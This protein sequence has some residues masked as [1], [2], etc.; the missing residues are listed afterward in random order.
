MKYQQVTLIERYLISHFNVKGY[1]ISN[2]AKELSRHKST[3]YRELKRNRATDGSYKSQRAFE[4]ATARRRRSRRNSHFTKSDWNIVDKHLKIDW[5]PEQISA[6]L[7][8]LGI[9]KISKETI[10]K[11]IWKDFRLGGKQHLLLRQ[12]PKKRRK[13]YRQYDSRGVL[14][15]KRHISERPKAAEKR[16]EIGHYE[17]DLVH[18]KYGG[19]PCVLTLVDRKSRYVV[20]SKLRNKTKKEVN[21]KL[22]PLIRRFGIKTI[23]SDNGVEFHGYKNVEKLTGVMFY[24]AT[25]H[26]SWERGTSENMNGLIRQYLPRTKT[27]RLTNQYKCN[28]IAKRLNTRPKKI[29]G[30][31][32]AKEV[33]F[34]NSN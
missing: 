16:L 34:G 15:G 19:K 29:H 31:K 9:L 30:Y 22:V 17:I 2:I 20:I 14:P 25:P 7:K 32:T 4:R 24:F 18:G 23:T 12:S 3:I 27:M 1:S 33:H 6:K 28:W 5:S 10:Y 26:H 8:E 11:R 21:R 13:R